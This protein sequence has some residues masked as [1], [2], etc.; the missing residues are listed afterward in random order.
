MKTTVTAMC[1]VIV[2]AFASSAFPDHRE[3]YKAYQASLAAGDLEAAV[4]HA[5]NAW[6]DA[7]QE[8]HD[9]KYTAILAYN[10]G[11]AV[12]E[13]DP[14]AAAAAFDRALHLTEIGVA[15]LDEKDVRL[16]ATLSHLEAD[17]KSNAAAK[18]LTSAL[19]T[20]REQ[21]GA[22]SDTSARGWAAAAS[23]EASGGSNAALARA[24]LLADN[25]GTD[26]RAM[27]PPSTRRLIE[28][29][30]VAA[31]ARIAGSQRRE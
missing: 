6:Q 8:L 5:K 11:Q 7:E 14:A 15:S 17:P 22:P 13:T 20:Y 21:G 27:S 1:A 16:N 24:V 26:A 12:A 2:F 29:L 31:V 9:H 4:T 25:A 30:F 3:E 23:A 19:T 10:Y 28:A 18:A